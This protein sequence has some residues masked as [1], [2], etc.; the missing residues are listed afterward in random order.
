[1]NENEIQV[2]MN[3]VFGEIRILEQNELTP[4]S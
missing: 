4:K 3:E 2:F 1:M